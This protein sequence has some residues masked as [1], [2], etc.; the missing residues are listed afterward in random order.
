MYASVAVS[1]VF[2]SEPQDAL[3]L[4]SE[5]LHGEDHDGG[6]DAKDD[7]DDEKFDEGEAALVAP[8]A[9]DARGV[10]QGLLAFSVFSLSSF[11]DEVLAR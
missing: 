10:A 2:M 9:P 5:V 7:D 1:T 4:S 6:Q 3:A 8:L 11:F